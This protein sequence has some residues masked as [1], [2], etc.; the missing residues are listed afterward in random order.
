[1]N[2]GKSTG[3]FGLERG[4]DMV[5]HCH[6]IFILVMEILFI[7]VRNDNEINGFEIKDFHL[8]LSAYADDAYFSSEMSGR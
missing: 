7:Q 5:I 6:H 1:M 3:Y 8:K 4:K 2:N